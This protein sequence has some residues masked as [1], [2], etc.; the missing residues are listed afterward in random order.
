M[1]QIAVYGKGGIGKSTV[2]A[3]VCAALAESG[4]K[5]WYIG[6]DPKSDGSMTLLGGRK[7]PTF[8]EQRKEGRTEAV[9]EG[10][11]G[12]KCV[13]TGGPLAGVGCAGRGI[14]VAVGELSRSYFRESDDVLIYDVPGDVVCG[15]FAAPLRE[16]FANEV[17]IVTSGEYLALYAANNIAKGLANLD[18]PLGGI[19][20][21][22]REVA[23]EEA[24]VKEFA[25]RI[26]SQLIGFVPRSAVVRECENQGMTVI[27][28]APDDSQAGAY[29]RLG[30][31]I[32]SNRQ[33]AVPSP[34]DPEN[35]RALL[36]EMS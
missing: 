2:S 5:V 14:I 10:F 17:Y 22:S 13:E 15:G 30:G 21:N 4:L 12:I 11:H 32:M 28:H 3:N 6:C 19:I 33:L 25:T 24:I 8:L 31:A 1:R 26:G 29:R 20:C 23:N 16:K 35:I 27:E 36:R 18:V 7:I 9:F 34:M